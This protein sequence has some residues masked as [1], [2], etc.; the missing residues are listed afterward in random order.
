M[1]VADQVSNVKVQGDFETTAFTIE[2][3]AQ[4]FITLSD[5]LYSNKILAIVRE[6]GINAYDSHVEAGCESVPIKVGIPT[7]FNREFFIEDEGLGLSH[8]DCMTVYQTYFKSTKRNS[9]S[10]VGC[11]G[12]GSKTPFCYTDNFTVTSVFDGIRREYTAFKNEHGIPQFALVSQEDTDAHNGVKISFSI[13]PSDSNKFYTAAKQAFEFLPV[14]PDFGSD[15]TRQ[16]NVELDQTDYEIKQKDWG[17]RSASQRNRG[18]YVVMGYIAYP[19]DPYKVDD[20][21]RYVH[22]ILHKNIDIFVNLSELDN[23]TPPPVSFTPSR[24]TLSYDKKTK[25]F[26]IDATKK[27]SDEAAKTFVKEIKQSSSLWQA[28]MKLNKL[29]NAGTTFS[30]L[31]KSCN[32]DNI[33]WKGQKIFD[34]LNHYICLDDP[35]SNA[36]VKEPIPGLKSEVFYKDG[37]KQKIV[38]DGKATTIHVHH[39]G[40]VYINDLNSGSVKR[41][42]YHVTNN[43][44]RNTKLFFVSFDETVNPDIKKKFMDKMGMIDSDLKYVSEL[45]DPPAEKGDIERVRTKVCKLSETYHDRWEDVEVDIK[46]G[47]IY[48]EIN[49][50]KAVSYPGCYNKDGTNQLSTMIGEL[51]DVGFVVPNIYGVKTFV[52]QQKR[53]KNAEWQTFEDYYN[54]CMDSI[55][56]NKETMKEI[57]RIVAI[58]KLFSATDNI[59]RS[60]LFGIGSLLPETHY[61]NSFLTESKAVTWT[62]KLTS[63]MELLQRHGHTWNGQNLIQKEKDLYVKYPMLGTYTR[64]FIGKSQHRTV[65]N[66]ILQTD[67]VTK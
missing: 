49:R 41:A 24:E 48:V 59:S 26:L 15:A 63:L 28:R 44:K 23:N 30:E 6:L 45:Y 62:T 11:L 21:N 37:W 57:E 22:N 17:F 31:A 20:S 36:F 25:K 27:I 4:T 61:I 14:K 46:D 42:S 43:V 19:I 33:K 9:N 12:L 56:T 34:N 16:S 7:A 60:D 13:N 51:K 55:L 18:S 58:S 40:N 39:S 66:Y 65:S 29:S 32:I 10:A 50:Y 54:Q 1:K 53:F 5:T 52:L 64:G 38:R 67:K 35:K 8:E 2:A 47:G 3:D